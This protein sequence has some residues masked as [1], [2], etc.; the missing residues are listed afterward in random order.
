MAPDLLT[1]QSVVRSLLKKIGVSPAK[2]LG[3]NFLVDGH[4]VSMIREHVSSKNPDVIVEIGP[5]LGALTQALVEVAPS[6]LAVEIDRRLA[7]S[8]ETRLGNHANLEVRTCDIL[9]FD[10]QKEFEGRSVLVFG[11]LPYRITAPI[12]KH[13]IRHRRVITDA[14]LITQREVAEKIAHSPGKHGSALGVFVH[15]YADVAALRRIGKTS[16]FPV[17]EVESEYWELSFLAA[18]RFATE[19]RAFFTVVRTLYGNRRKMV[20]RALQ[21]ILPVDRIHDVLASAQVDGTARGET[22]SFS[23]LDCLAQLCQPHLIVNVAGSEID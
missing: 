12:L 11:S 2:R 1:D 16:F 4:V 7:K 22:L 9:Q 23:E 19:E 21:D 13:L 20:R 17:P 5:G 18:P 3:Q 14:C 10:F 15:S 8:L 6:V